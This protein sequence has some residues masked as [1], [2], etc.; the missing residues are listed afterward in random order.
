MTLGDRR[1]VAALLSF[2]SLTLCLAATP[3]AAADD[4]GALRADVERLKADVEALK[5]EMR[6][7]REVIVQRLAPAG[8][9][10]QATAEV[11]VA[12][13]PSLGRADAP[14]TLV[15]FSDYQCPYCRRFFASTLPTLK[16]E[17]IDT[18]KIR[19]VFRDFPLESIHPHAKKAAE[20]AHCAGEQGQ[21]WPMHDTLFGSQEALEASDL[22]NYAARL[23]LDV[24]AFTTCV[25][26]GK[27]DATVQ[28]NVAEGSAAGVDGTPAFVVGRT[29]NAD[30]IDG[31]MIKGAQPIDEFRR[32]I[33]RVLAGQ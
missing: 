31:V 6:I 21:Y 11:K 9:G 8:R 10:P 25:E 22:R 18:G 20:A 28:T 14:V 15:E 4:V 19:Y 5:N 32:A 16:K 13:S 27:Y 23:G 3:V 17:Y 2:V 24:P 30:P 33:E 26:S 12:G 1:T 29:R 7:M